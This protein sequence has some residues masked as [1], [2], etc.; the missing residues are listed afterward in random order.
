MS[1]NLYEYVWL[2]APLFVISALAI[3]P[4]VLAQ[5][6]GYNFWLFYA[7]GVVV[8]L[9]TIAVVFFL[10]DKNDTGTKAATSAFKVCPSCGEDNERERRVCA[11]CGVRFA[12]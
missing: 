8:W 6:K 2:L 3:V 1:S 12:T 11:R 10:P 4:A 7:F 5:R 9:V